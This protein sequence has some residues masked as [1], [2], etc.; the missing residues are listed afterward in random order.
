MAITSMF[1]TGTDGATTD[2]F[3][4]RSNSDPHRE[5][6]A[7]VSV[8]ACGWVDVFNDGKWH[9]AYTPDEIAEIAACSEWRR[10]ERGQAAPSTLAALV[11]AEAALHRIVN[12]QDSR[13]A[14]DAWKQARAAL[15]A[16]QATT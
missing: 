5:R 8:T 7:Y 1:R 10:S 4:L 6:D 12:F 15:D 9:V 3:V 13:D 16:I 2:D 14:E 11:D